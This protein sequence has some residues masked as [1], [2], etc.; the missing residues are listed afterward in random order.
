MIGMQHIQ[1]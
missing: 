1:K